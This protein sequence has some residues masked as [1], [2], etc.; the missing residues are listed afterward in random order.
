MRSLP[1]QKFITYLLLAGNP[2]L[3]ISQYIKAYKLGKIDGRGMRAFVLA[4]KSAADIDEL[5]LIEKIEKRNNKRVKGQ[6]VKINLVVP[7]GLEGLAQKLKLTES[8]FKNKSVKFIIEN[9]MLRR[10]IEVYL[11][12]KIEF[13][14]IARL[15]NSKFRLRLKEKDLESYKEWMYDLSVM[16]PDDMYKYFGTLER[17]EQEYKYMAFMNKEDFVKWKMK[18]ECSIDP[19]VSTKKMMADAFYNFQEILDMR[20]VNHAAAKAWSEIY[21][22]CMDHL[23]SGTGDKDGQV[24]AQFQ[25]NLVKD[26][27]KKPITFEE[28]LKSGK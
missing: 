22:K 18:D 23:E 21:F 8:P 3:S 11:T 5:S 16:P 12:T 2:T 14:E 27:T 28:L 17:D 15:V 26:K 9:I 10:S 24:F 13:K 19:K 20:P 6:A 1:Y 25:F 4:V 7:E